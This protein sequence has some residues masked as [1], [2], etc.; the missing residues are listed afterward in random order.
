MIFLSGN[1]HY[2][3]VIV[4]VVED[5]HRAST[6]FYGLV[7]LGTDQTA[8]AQFRLLKK[9]FEDD[10]VWTSIKNNIVALVSLSEVQCY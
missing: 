8:Q 5:N 7:K 6:H 3:S 10:N 9:R 2:L 4:I 1:D